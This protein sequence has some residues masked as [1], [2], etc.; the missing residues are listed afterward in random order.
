[1]DEA[2]SS[3]RRPIVPA[4][5][6]IALAVLSLVGFSGTSAAAPPRGIPAR[7]GG[8]AHSLPHLPHLPPVPPV[9][10]APDLPVSHP[11]EGRD[12][13]PV[14]ADP[15]PIVKAEEEPD[16]PPAT[17]SG[18]QEPSTR[19]GR[20]GAAACLSEARRR[21]LPLAPS[22]PALGVL[23]P[24]RFNGPLHG[25]RF[26][27]GLPEPQQKTSVFEIVDCRLALALDD[28]G[29][30]LE[31]RDII[32]VVHMSAYRPPAEKYWPN[33]QLGTRHTGALALDAAVFVKRDGTKLSV[34]RDY[35]G[36]IGQKPCGHQSGPWPATPAG[37]EL[38][39]ITCE[40]IAAKL[41]HVVLTPGF[42]AAHRNHFHL[43]VA[44]NGDHSYIR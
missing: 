17:P 42:N 43:E 26:H 1:M 37:V 3:N 8:S 31:A 21:Q 19:Y 16:V 20:M 35:H 7:V 10:P 14:P 27:S 4:Q 40:L 28:L 23:A 15:A 36:Y 5:I 9:P 13:S 29:A 25:V 6:G 24:V 2:S 41:F 30:L 39:K 32:E 34:E 11:G 44:A 33:A 22:G 12:S 38:R 18:T